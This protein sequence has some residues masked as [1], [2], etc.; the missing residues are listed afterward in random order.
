ME[1]RRGFL[2]ILIPCFLLVV[3]GVATPQATA[4][5]PLRG[6][7]IGVVSGLS[8]AF[9]ILGLRWLGRSAENGQE[10]AGTAVLARVSFSFV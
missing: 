2:Y 6:N 7:L 1:V 8:W 4:P 9:T 5:D 3:V 10:T